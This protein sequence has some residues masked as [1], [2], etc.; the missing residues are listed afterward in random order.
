MMKVV[1][2]KPGFLEKTQDVINSYASIGYNEIQR[3]QIVLTKEQCETIW[4]DIK[5]KEQ[6]GQ[7]IP[8]YFDRYCTYIMS[9]YCNCIYITKNAISNYQ[10]VIDMKNALRKKY[11]VHGFRDLLHSSDSSENAEIEFSCIFE[12]N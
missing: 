9:G 1:I 6:E 2:I 7:L 8:G 12:Q 5:Q 3:T 4:G 10:E 11:N